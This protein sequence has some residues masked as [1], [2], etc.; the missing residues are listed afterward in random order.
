LLPA[1][2][3]NHPYSIPRIP[4]VIRAIIAVTHI[5]TSL[6]IKAVAIP[7]SSAFITIIIIEFIAAWFLADDH[8]L[9][10]NAAS[11]LSDLR[12]FLISS[13][14]KAQVARLLAVN[15]ALQ[16]SFLLHLVQSPSINH[17][18]LLSSSMFN[19]I[20]SQAEITFFFH[21]SSSPSVV[22]RTAAIRKPAVKLIAMQIMYPI[23]I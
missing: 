15:S 3:S 16:Y 4:V 9:L 7:V 6:R 10:L 2:L 22:P 5:F 20:P 12:F 21:Q 19:L 14:M 23:M 13:L 1:Y 11:I 17:L 8:N 18:S